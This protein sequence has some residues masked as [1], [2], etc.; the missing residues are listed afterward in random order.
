MNNFFLNGEPIS[1]QTVSLAHDLPNQVWVGTWG[2]GLYK[3]DYRSRQAEKIQLK[4][5]K[6]QGTNI[7]FEV[8]LDLCFDKDK[9]LWVGTDG[10]GIC[11]IKPK[12]KFNHIYYSP[13][14]GL[15]KAQ[16]LSVCIDNRDVIWVG[17]RGSGLCY[18]EDGS[19]IN[20]ISDKNLSKLVLSIFNN[21]DGNLS[22]GHDRGLGIISYQKGRYT[23]TS[24]AKFYDSPAFN[25]LTKVISRLEDEQ[26][27]WVGTQEKGLYIF[28]KTNDKF[29]LRRNLTATPE[30]PGS[31]Q[32][33]RIS[34]LY[35]DSENNIWVGTFGGL[36]IFSRSDSS[37]LSVNSL[38]DNVMFLTSE[39][40]LD[41]AEDKFKNIWVATP[42]GLNKIIKK[43]NGRFSL[44]TY[45]LKEG[46]LSDYIHAILYNGSDELWLSTNNGI[47]RFDI[48]RENFINYGESDGLIDRNFS[49]GAS[50]KA[51]GKFFFG[52]IN[53]LLCFNPNEINV[54]KNKPDIKFTSFEI[55]NK[56]VQVGEKI[57][58]RVILPA[59]LNNINELVLTYKEQE[60]TFTFTA[61]DYIS[62]ERNLYA[63]RLE[64]YNDSWSFLGN[65][66][67]VSFNNLKPGIYTLK[68]KGSN[69]NNV[70]NEKGASIKI[71]V[72]PPPWRTWYAFVVYAI[73]VVLL[74]YLIWAATFKRLQLEQNLELEKLRS[75]QE[76]EINKVKID[77]FTSISHEI[78]TPLTLILAP[79][80]DLIDRF[81]KSDDPAIRHKLNLV[82]MNAN[83]LHNLINQ[84]LDFRKVESDEMKIMAGKGNINML[85]EEVVAPYRE[86]ADKE[87]K[88]LTLSF[89]NSDEEFW[90]DTKMMEIILNNLLSNAFKFCLEEGEVKMV[91]SN[92]DRF[93]Y[94]DVIDDGPGI[95]A[96]ELEKV[97]NR[98]Y[99]SRLNRENGGTGIGLFLVKK[100]IDLHS[101]SIE[102]NC[103]PGITNFRIGFL[104][105]REHFNNEQLDLSNEIVT[106]GEF[107]EL[108]QKDELTAHAS[109]RQRHKLLI[110]DDNKELRDYLEDKFSKD[111]I[112]LTADNGLDGYQI[113]MSEMPSLI[114]SDI[115]MPKLDGLE[116]CK[117]VKSNDRIKNIP[118][119][120]LTARSTSKYQFLGT[121]L[122]ADDY[123]IKPF[124][125][126]I[127]KSKID[128]IIKSR[129]QLQKQY[130]QKVVLEPSQVEISNSDEEFLKKILEVI[131][132]HMDNSE[133]NPQ[134]LASMV[135]MSQSSLYRRLQSSTHKT[136]NEMIREMRIKRAAQLLYDKQKS[137]TDI[138]YDVGF[139]D[140]KYFRSCFHK[141]FGK[142]PS[143]FRAENSN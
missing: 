138:V 43:G 67:Y 31:L 41:I 81:S 40:I 93:I 21:A 89:N 54:N 71:R 73:I 20:C 127:F 79:L 62:S 19:K 63:Y 98:F 11:Q 129:V 33:D 137:I 92:N 126:H 45:S 16:I 72:L 51:N 15:T 30:I 58:N 27:L 106:D 14:K 36:H 74:F 50:N 8:I 77:F 3:F 39:I 118:F 119:V 9:A 49:N 22:V 66:N 125:I 35:K 91:V 96:D 128:N 90:F 107:L 29:Q 87:A 112:V 120:L 53:G 46:L 64:G 111:Y 48:T 99:Q 113:I 121:R 135:N 32:N 140:V 80:Q 59:S 76:I 78:R 102:V 97:F 94:I 133:F 75:E 44:K 6:R 18:S 13:D 136:I 2:G 24:A 68:V 34:K 114:V 23:F 83:R 105:G 37:F 101:G 82:A 60:V 115:S 124:N 56:E 65:K 47:S 12:Q 139:N 7:D 130:S 85:I 100:L 69:H 104:K 5:K 108:S 86:L 88:R 132:K 1:N 142:T 70:W 42:N 131:E 117:R 141:Q 61:L 116:L 84:L 109:D 134:T 57:N 52:G 122:G 17:T 26:S 38:I 95:P 110:V 28:E 55:F 103:T 123:V 143:E 4:Q 25:N 10:G